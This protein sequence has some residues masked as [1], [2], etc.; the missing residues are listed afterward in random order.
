MSENTNITMNAANVAVA[1]NANEALYLEVVKVK[2]EIFDA[3]WEGECILFPLLD[4]GFINPDTRD[5]LRG[6]AVRRVL[7]TGLFYHD[8]W[9]TFGLPTTKEAM[10]AKTFNTI[11]LGGDLYK[12]PIDP[13]TYERGQ[14]DIEFV[15]FIKDRIY[16]HGML[17]RK[18]AE[19]VGEFWACFKEAHKQ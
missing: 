8:N 2:T 6:E 5:T 13:W 16:R 15:K 17:H 14:I 3:E 9:W 10:E 19:L 12:F 18:E 1:T 4:E 7:S 11:T